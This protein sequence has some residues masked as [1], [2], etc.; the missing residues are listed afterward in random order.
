[1]TTV[2]VMR[3]ENI[4]KELGS[5]AGLVVAVKGVSLELRKM[6]G[7]SYLAPGDAPAVAAPS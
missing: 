4:V 2:P 5:G 3:A 1:M 6:T 7:R